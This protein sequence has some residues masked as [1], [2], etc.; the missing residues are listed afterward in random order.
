[1]SCLPDC[2]GEKASRLRLPPVPAPGSA[3]SGDLPALSRGQGSSSPTPSRPGPAHPAGCTHSKGL[4]RSCQA[5]CV[6]PE[7]TLAAGH[8]EGRR[9]HRALRALQ[10]GRAACGVPPL[11]P[12]GPA[13][14]AAES[15]R[16]PTCVRPGAPQPLST[17]AGYALCTYLLP[18]SDPDR[19]P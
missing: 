15:Q 12:R 9:G 8:A 19:V 10:R 2:E 13:R 18:S 6:A 7:P 11:P 5:V 4:P 14:W 16:P 1:M 17:S 3:G